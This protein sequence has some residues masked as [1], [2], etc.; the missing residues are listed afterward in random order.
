M[1]YTLMI[2]AIVGIAC[3]AITVAGAS[4][5]GD[6][7]DT[8]AKKQLSTYDKQIQ[9]WISI[10]DE[11]ISIVRDRVK[12]GES[13]KSSVAFAIRLLGKMR[14]PEAAPALLEAFDFCQET[15]LFE[16]RIVPP[17]HK[18]P[19]R[20]ALIKIGDWK[21]VLKAVAAKKEKKVLEDYAYVL[22]KMLGAR[23]AIAA[24]NEAIETEKAPDRSNNLKQ[25]R[26]LC[27]SYKK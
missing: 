9:K 24:V 2:T 5:T 12:L 19:A 15:D 26:I 23:I 20:G 16:D 18:Y 7:T 8:D 27:A 3:V 21:P 6:L 13:K 17:E 10:R 22:V 1:K 14:S 25:L 4:L 11:L